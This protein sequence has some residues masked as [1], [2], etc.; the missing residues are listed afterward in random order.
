MSDDGG[1]GAKVKSKA[2]SARPYR[3]KS[4]TLAQGTSVALKLKDAAWESPLDGLG[5]GVKPSPPIRMGAGRLQA[6]QVSRLIAL[7]ERL[8]KDA[9]RLRFSKPGALL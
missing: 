4:R 2:Y 5:G 3:K 8:S 6:E 7:D 9:L 1:H